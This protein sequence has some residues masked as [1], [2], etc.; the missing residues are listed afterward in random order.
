MP[1]VRGAMHT[2]ADLQAVF[3]SSCFG[4]GKQSELY[5]HEHTKR[6]SCSNAN[7]QCESSLSVVVLYLTKVW[8]TNFGWPHSQILSH[9]PA[10]RTCTSHVPRQIVFVKA[11]QRDRYARRITRADSQRRSCCGGVCFN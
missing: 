6:G 1:T 7:V 2:R 3:L 11:R 9:A 8:L 5:L 4:K 10:T